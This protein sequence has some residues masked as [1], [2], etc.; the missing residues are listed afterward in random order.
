MILHKN[1]NFWSRLCGHWLDFLCF[2]ALV[3]PH[4]WFLVGQG[5]TNHFSLKF[6]LFICV[7][8]LDAAILFVGIPYLTAGRTVGMLINRL[9]FIAQTKAT[10][11][12]LHKIIWQKA[13]FSCG[14]WLLT[15]LLFIILIYP[16][17]FAAFKEAVV[18]RD[19]SNFRYT[20]AARLI[21]SISVLGLLLS[22]LNYI[23]ILVKKNKL[24]F[25]DFFTNTRTVYLKHYNKEL[26]NTMVRL[27]PF[28]HSHQSYTFAQK[29]NNETTT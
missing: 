19:T 5:T 18:K 28:K 15:S 21:G 20:I 23:M 14:F 16:Q 10:K 2:C 6:Y 8:N 12:N 11:F 27:I 9:Q 25:T 29:T 3:L 1:A 24:G 13:I 4:Y 17:D 22:T 26:L 7:S